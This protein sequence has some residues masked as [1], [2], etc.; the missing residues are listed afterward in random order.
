MNIEYADIF[1]D[2]TINHMTFID[3]LYIFKKKEKN[4]EKVEKRSLRIKTF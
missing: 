4:E 3:M 2:L 1:Q